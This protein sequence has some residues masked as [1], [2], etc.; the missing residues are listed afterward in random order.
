MLWCKV[1]KPAIGKNDVADDIEADLNAYVQ[2]RYFKPEVRNA[3][4]HYHGDSI[5]ET[6]DIIYCLNPE[7]EIM[8]AWKF[9]DILD[10]IRTILC[11][12]EDN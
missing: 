1:I 6:L 5:R 2:I 4:A 11:K 12:K 8:A 9:L 7:M 3:L 10:E